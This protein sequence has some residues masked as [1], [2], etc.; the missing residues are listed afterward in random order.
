MEIFNA[1]DGISPWYW[2]AFALALGALE[3]AT[4]SFFLIWPALAALVVGCVLLVSPSLSGPAQVS[5]FSL[6]S[7]ALT[8]LGRIVLKRYGDGGGTDDMM[9]N[10]RGQR[11]IGRTAIVS[12]FSSGQ[13][14]I[15]VEGMRWRAIWPED[16]SSKPG[17][18]V[19]VTRADGLILCVEAIIG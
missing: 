11:F 6:G 13:G 17:D 15:E 19:R 3:M 14:Y 18:Q 4:F 12:E 10:R 9:L 7:I 16:Q 5:I 2:L 1:L 8:V